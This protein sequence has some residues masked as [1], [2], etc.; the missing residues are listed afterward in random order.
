MSKQYHTVHWVAFFILFFGLTKPA[1]LAASENPQ[2]GARSRGLA[3]ASITLTDLWSVNNNQAA[4]AFLNQGGIALTY[5]NRFALKELALKGL[6]GALP[7]K[8]GTFGV[9]V[10]QFGFDQYSEN[11]F[12]LAYGMLLGR[13]IS[14][15]IQLDYLY[16][17]IADDFY[18]AKNAFTAELG[19]MAKAT[20]NLT[21]GAHV[22][23]L[24][25]TSF[26]GESKQ[27]IP[28]IFRLGLDYNFSD[29]VTTILEVEKNIDRQAM[30]KLGIEYHPIELLYL[31]M[32]VRSTEFQ[33]A[34]GAG[35]NWK[36]LQVDIGA[37]YQN[38][39]G[40]TSQFTLG[41]QFG[42]K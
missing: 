35:I 16:V 12:G 26:S 4:L 18:P 29:K 22:Y 11:K 37:S 36:G 2:S 14:L 34:F 25:N 28:M 10:Q 27:R 1:I 38:Y 23:N 30:V 21:V 7:F 32:G 39:L 17:A 15:G 33:F 13:N 8:F 20:K 5:E 31:R 40:F 41:Y 24:V 19:F 6:T 9:T 3:T 42:K